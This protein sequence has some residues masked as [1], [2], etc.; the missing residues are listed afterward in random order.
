MMVKKQVSSSIKVVKSR[1]IIGV[2]RVIDHMVWER[3]ERNDEESDLNV[4]YNTIN[5]LPTK[6]SKVA[7]S[8]IGKQNFTHLTHPQKT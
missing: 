2:V 7:A 4:S 3:K 6:L 8:Y 5:E 1:G